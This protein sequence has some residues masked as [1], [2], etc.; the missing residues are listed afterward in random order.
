MNITQKIIEEI[1]SF[2]GIA[3]I[4]RGKTFHYQELLKCSLEFAQILAKS[5]VQA[6]MRVGL[7]ADDSFE[8]IAASLALL[9]LNAALVPL[10]TRA[11]K[12]ELRR[13][14][15]QVGLNAL[16]APAEYK[17]DD[18]EQ[19]PVPNLFRMPFYLTLR[20][21]KIDRF[22]LPGGRIPAFIRFSSGTTGSNKGVILSHDAV[23]ERTSACTG[24][25]VTRGEYV[26]W[27][28]DM[29]FH[30]VV[31]IL[32]FLRKGA[33]IVICERPIESNMRKAIAEYPIR[34][35]YAT[36]YHYRLMTSSPDF[37]PDSLRGIRLALSTAM[38]LELADA[39]A[40][41]RKFGL[42]LNQAYGI[43]E[44]GLPCI[45]NTDDESKFDSAG[46][47][48]DAYE[49]KI[50]SPDP[51][52]LGAVMIRGPGMFDAYL[53]P[54]RTRQEICPDGWFATGDIGRVDPDRCLF[55][56][57]RSKNVIIFA[58][59]KIF[60]YEVESVLNGFAFVE[61]SRVSGKKI[62][63][64]GEIP[65]AEIV[66]KP[67]APADWAEILRK[68]CFRLLAAYK[69]PKEFVSVQSLPHTASGKIQRRT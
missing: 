15:D 41:R 31:T 40:F 12:E 17:T 27:V 28:L 34:L 20:T 68:D 53:S 2:D 43:I 45:N 22:E 19:L 65:V 21:N 62:P 32:L 1:G 57:G 61:E 66:L 23:L 44:V 52:G 46:R 47:I 26:L 39:Q 24:L 64:L 49:L 35:L 36:P 63:G 25:G 58:G 3:V 30:F 10:S 16:L 9:S 4:D 37:E 54:F 42:P 69:V 59:M 51:N 67:D 11:S 38:K 5:G 14:P 50:D 29:A 13:M 7:I 56:A 33:A 60:P 48:Q 6:G 8:Y 18:A 55:I